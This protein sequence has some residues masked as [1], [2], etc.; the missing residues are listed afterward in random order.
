MG[1]LAGYRRPAAGTQPSYLHAPYKS[2]LRRAASKPLVLL[3]HTLSE[4]TGP[5]F[6]HDAIRPTD[7]DLTRQHGGEPLGERMIVSGRVLDEDGRPVPCAR[8][9]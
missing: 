7:H 6:G 1:E 8:D 3:P 5:V 4:V 9:V 2:T